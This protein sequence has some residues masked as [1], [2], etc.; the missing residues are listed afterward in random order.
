MCALQ[1]YRGREGEDRVCPPTGFIAQQ[2]LGGR[3]VLK[4]PSPSGRR[5]EGS[6]GDAH[7]LSSLDWCLKSQGGWVRGGEDA[8]LY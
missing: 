7:T 1:A 4:C 3:A 8:V 2:S 6:R 5:K